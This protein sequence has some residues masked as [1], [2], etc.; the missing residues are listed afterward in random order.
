MVVI[1]NVIR[2]A[3]FIFLF[4]ALIVCES[5]HW[6]IRLKNYYN[7]DPKIYNHVLFHSLGNRYIF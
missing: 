2:G 5:N 3:E 6:V 4:S 1:K 7:I